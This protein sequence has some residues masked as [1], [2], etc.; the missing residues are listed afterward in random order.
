MILIRYDTS[1]FFGIRN[2]QFPKTAAN[3]YSVGLL[4][5]KGPRRKSGQNA[6]TTDVHQLNGVHGADAD[7]GATSDTVIGMN[8]IMPRHVQQHDGPHVT[9]FGTGAAVLA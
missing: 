7:T 9:E 8:L 2:P 3:G 6:D 1:P 5:K 4:G